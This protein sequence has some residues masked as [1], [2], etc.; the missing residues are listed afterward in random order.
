MKRAALDRHWLIC[1]V[2]VFCHFLLASTCQRTLWR[3]GAG[4]VE[5]L[6]WRQVDLFLQGSLGG[7]EDRLC[8]GIP[9]VQG[10][11]VHTIP[12]VC[13]RGSML[14]NMLHQHNPVIFLR[15]FLNNTFLMIM[16]R[17]CM[18]TFS[19]KQQG[20]FIFYILFFFF[21]QR[22]QLLKL[23]RIISRRKE[24]NKFWFS[25]LCSY[26]VRLQWHITVE[27]TQQTATNTVRCWT[28]VGTV[29]VLVWGC[30]VKSC[31]E[32]SLRS[33]R[34]LWIRAADMTILFDPLVKCVP[35]AMFLQLRMKIKYHTMQLER[36]NSKFL[37]YLNT[38]WKVYEEQIQC[39]LMAL[40]IPPGT[41]VYLLCSP[42]S[43][44]MGH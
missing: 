10:L 6:P 28:G 5:L 42:T 16:I 19:A 41:E 39:L 44:W 32:F 11:P 35:A 2:A 18:K 3:I 25:P 8:R 4:G 14:D 17:P 26:C 21:L 20:T 9:V 34:I 15:T 37:N 23:H 30:K 12:H 33:D 31:F 22:N 7:Q 13:I 40:H 27:P 29:S 43:I 24:Q 38:D 1:Y 36:E